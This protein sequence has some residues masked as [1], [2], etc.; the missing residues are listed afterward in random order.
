MALQTK[1]NYKLTKAQRELIK[2]Y[3]AYFVNT[4]GNEIEELIE[5][6][7]VNF[8]NNYVAAA[9]QMG[10]YSQ[11]LMLENLKRNELLGGGT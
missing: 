2:Q 11:L 7:D 4:G 10:L 9:M 3:R 5:R 6:P 8:F 1:V